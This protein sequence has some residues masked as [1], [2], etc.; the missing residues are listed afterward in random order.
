MD[1]KAILFWDS[2]DTLIEEDS[3]IRPSGSPIVQ[4]GNFHKNAD[5]VLEK[6]K[7]KGYKMA[8]VA[9]GYKESF[10]NLYVKTG[11]SCFLEALI[12]SE[13][14]GE[15]K[16]SKNM[17]QAA[18]DALGLEDED[19]PYIYMIGNNLERDVVGANRFGIHSVLMDWSPNYRMTPET[20]EEIPEY[21][22]H[23]AD[24]IWKIITEEG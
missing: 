14:I 19:K 13:E 23:S 2:G 9:D 4:K 11:V 6:L 3:E 15:C 8:L 5:K 10:S 17:F 7:D 21:R 20:E 22:I 18:M 12:T 1:K 16:P 24:E